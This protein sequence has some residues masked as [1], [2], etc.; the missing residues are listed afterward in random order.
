[1]SFLSPLCAAHICAALTCR[2]WGLCRCQEMTFRGTSDGARFRARVCS[3]VYGICTRL[4]PVLGCSPPRPWATLFLS[5]DPNCSGQDRGGCG[6]R[7]LGSAFSWA[8][9]H[10]VSLDARSADMTRVT[11]A[12]LAFGA[13]VAWGWPLPFGLTPASARVS[14]AILSILAATQADSALW[15]T[16]MLGGFMPW[17]WGLPFLLRRSIVKRS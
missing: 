2:I 4:F 3:S 6:H 9:S 15:P 5:N 1:M 14:G 17:G 16:M 8:C 10:S 12:A 13:Y 7:V 11:R